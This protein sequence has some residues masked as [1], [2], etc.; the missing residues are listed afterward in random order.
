[1]A[2]D[3]KHM[4]ES[5]FTM[6]P[7]H[8]SL[9]LFLLVSRKP[10]QRA[11]CP[12]FPPTYHKRLN[13]SVAPEIATAEA[14]SEPKVKGYSLVFMFFVVADCPRCMEVPTDVCLLCAFGGMDI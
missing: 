2:D 8:V 10:Y 9:L 3:E 6:P 4:T 12:L 7:T 11:R 5:K 14:Y 13:N 1:M